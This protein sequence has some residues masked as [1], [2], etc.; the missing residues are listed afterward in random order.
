MPVIDVSDVDFGPTVKPLDNGDLRITANAHLEELRL[1]PVIVAR[2]PALSE[3]LALVGASGIRNL[4]TIGGN[5]A[6]GLGDTEILLVALGAQALFAGGTRIAIGNSLP[7]DVLMTAIEVP[8]ALSANVFVEKVGHRAS[9][10]P[11][12]VVVSGCQLPDGGWLIA[13]RLGPTRPVITIL[14]GESVDIEAFSCSDP[15]LARIATNLIRRHIRLRRESVAW[16]CKS[17]KNSP[18]VFAI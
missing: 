12:K 18:D 13:D 10:S 3:L 14:S 4:A 1:D 6:W 15:H 16:A 2:L 11:A 9:F 8:P 5:L 7:T 17:P